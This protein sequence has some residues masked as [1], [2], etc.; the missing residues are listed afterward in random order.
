MVILFLATNGHSHFLSYFCCASW[1]TILHLTLSMLAVT[2]VVAH[3]L[4]P[5]Q[6]QYNV[7]PDLDSN[8]LTLCL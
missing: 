1:N 4:D 2:C 7:G 6:D 5:D 3:G 8:S